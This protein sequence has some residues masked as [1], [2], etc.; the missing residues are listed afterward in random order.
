MTERDYS[1]TGKDTERAIASG[2]AA[3]EWPDGALPRAAE[4]PRGDQARPAAASPGIIAAY[5]EM[6]PTFIRQ[7]R[8]E[9]YFLK[10]ELPP[11]ARPYRDDLH[12]GGALPA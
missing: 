10:R 8:Y 4:A 6:I 1:L 5:R 7:L 2:L 9:D 3:A 12:T 11:T